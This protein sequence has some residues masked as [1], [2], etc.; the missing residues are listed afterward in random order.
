MKGAWFGGH[1]PCAYKV[2]SWFHKVCSFTFNLVPLY[3][4]GADLAA[5]CREAALAA[6]EEDLASTAVS[7]R[8][9]AV[10][11]GRVPPSPPPPPELSATY[12]RFKRPGAGLTAV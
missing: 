11:T 7:A 9:F 2:I 12:E 10:A 6:L 8:H 3:T 1:N 4:T 5:V